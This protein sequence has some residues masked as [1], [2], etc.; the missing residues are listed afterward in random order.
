MDA[1]TLPSTAVADTPLGLPTISAGA[2]DPDSGQ[3]C[4]M[5]YV[6]LL[7]DEPWSDRPECTHPILAHEARVV[8]DLIPD[9]DRP[10]LVPLIGRLF[11]TSAD[12]DA[13]RAA[14]RRQQARH[15]MTLI[16]PDARGPVLAAFET[17]GRAEDA[18]E[19]AHS[20]RPQPSRL[21]PEHEQ[22]HLEGR[23]VTAFALTPQLGEAEAWA[24]AALVTAHTV[25]AAECRA[26]CGDPVARARRGIRELSQ[27]I[28]AYDDATARV[29]A[30]TTPEQIQ[31]L[32][33]ALS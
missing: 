10:R 8:N 15:V 6:S 11:G 33:G 32:A 2:H 4:V 19:R 12:S 24:L 22:W 13:I 20:M 3:A 30:S 7:A 9:I 29:A 26:N 31:L 14:V 27:L 5:E 28:D 16:E 17:S 25:A 18:V 21:D 23:R 1:E